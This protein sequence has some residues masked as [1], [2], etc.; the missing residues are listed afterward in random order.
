[1]FL[2]CNFSDSLFQSITMTCIS[3]TTECTP[4]SKSKKFTTK[5]QELTNQKQENNTDHTLSGKNTISIFVY[6]LQVH[7][8]SYNSNKSTNQMQH[9][10]NFIT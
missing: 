3:T 1:M 6:S 5:N 4:L 10:L 2:G 8:S 9:F 7:A